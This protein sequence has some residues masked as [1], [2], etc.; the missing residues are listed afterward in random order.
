MRQLRRENGSETPVKF[1]YSWPH[2][3]EMWEYQLLKLSKR[4][5]RCIAYHKRSFGK[6][7]R[8]WQ[9]YDYEPL[10]DDLNQLIIELNLLK[11]VLTGFLMGGGEVAR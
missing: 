3:P 10:A 8:A 2:N 11:L 7:D 9:N 1:I 5:I 6:S 4:N